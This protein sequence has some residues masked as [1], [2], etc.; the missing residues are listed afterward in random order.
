[1][2]VRRSVARLR[3]RLRRVVVRTP[4]LWDAV[5]LARP[6]K[7]STLAGRASAIVIEGFQRSG[8]TFSVAAF[9]VANGPG[10]HIGRHLHGAPHFQRAARFGVPAVLLIRRPF[11]AVCSY[12]V[13]WPDLTPEDAFVEYLD[14]YRTAWRVRSQVVVAPFDTVVTDFGAVIDAVNQ[15]Y[16]TSFV[17]YTGTPENQA[18]AFALVEEMN[19]EE[20]GG[21][22]VETHVGRPSGERGAGKAL[23]EAALREPRTQRLLAQADELYERFVRMA[24]VQSP[25]NERVSD[26]T[27]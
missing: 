14:F 7:R 3:H 10:P 16:R 27:G 15:R 1:V 8:N 19:R 11:D 23:V 6:G 12:V 17:R 26:E 21:E 18:A 25:P 9:V 5:M 22:V 2:R 20:C 4:Y 24:P 13:R